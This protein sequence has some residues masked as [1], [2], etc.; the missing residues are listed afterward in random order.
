MERIFD[1]NSGD[2]RL[3][4]IPNTVVANPRNPNRMPAACSAAQIR[5]LNHN[6]VVGSLEAQISNHQQEAGCSEAREQQHH[7]LSRAAIFS[8]A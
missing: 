8:A 5:H 3:T 2:R 4:D 7:N 6:R 1:Y